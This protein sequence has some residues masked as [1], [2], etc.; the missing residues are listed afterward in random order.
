VE[1]QTR[2]SF[3]R[4]WQSFI[5]SSFTPQRLVRAAGSLQE[6]LG[7]EHL[8]GQSFLDIGC[9]SGLFSLAALMLGAERV[10]SFDYDPFSVQASK[11]LRERAGASEDRWTIAQ[12]SVLDPAFMGALPEADVVYSW[13]VLHHT[14]SMWQAI[15]YAAARVCPGGVLAIAIYN[16]TERPLGG[17]RAWW[18]IKRLYNQ[19]P[20]VGRYAIEVSYASVVL[21]QLALR[22]QSPIEYVRGYSAHSMR[23]MEF[24][25]DVRDWVG[26]FPYESATMQELEAYLAPRGF[27]ATFR[28]PNEGTGCHEVALRRYG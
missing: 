1:S 11:E 2:F 19:L 18:Q 20:A 12:G 24:W 8:V 6:M 15:D 5:S 21:A 13:G 27:Q 7:R 10:I 23:G 3:G 28:R 4:N 9:G 26:G 17:S 22:G 16:R 25:H 14:G